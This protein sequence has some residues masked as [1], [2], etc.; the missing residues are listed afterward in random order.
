MGFSSLSSTILD[1]AGRGAYQSFSGH[2]MRAMFGYRA[3]GPLQAFSYSVTREKA[4]VFI[5]GSP[6]PRGLARGKRGFAGTM[7][8]VMLD[9]SA[10]LQAMKDMRFVSLRSEIHPDFIASGDEL[11]TES[12]PLESA[13][14]SML[15]GLSG[16]DINAV[17]DPGSFIKDYA[18]TQPYFVDQIPPFEV[19]LLAV[20]EMGAAARMVVYGAEILNEGS[21]FSI[22]DLSVEEQMTYVAMNMYPWVRVTNLLREAI[23]K[24]GS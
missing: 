19:S 22:D 9:Q 16:G 21:G 1:L 4:P 12:M 23:L 2:T 3:I 10:L 15:L 7:V 17:P 8:F 11:E 18:L 13:N 14:A 5:F 6:N 20:N 24:Q